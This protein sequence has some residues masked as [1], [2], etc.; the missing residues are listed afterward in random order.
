MLEEAETRNRKF[1]KMLEEAIRQANRE[2]IDPM[3]PPVSVDSILP[4]AIMVAK[5]RGRYLAEAF[6]LVS[7]KKDGFPDEEQISKLREYREAYEE[8]LNVSQALEHAIGRG[9]LE[10]GE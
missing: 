1:T 10:L 7:N 3:L 6:K 4:I 5:L 9:Y 8:A 2:V